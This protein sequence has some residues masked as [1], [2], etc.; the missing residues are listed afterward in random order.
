MNSGF[1]RDK[2]H[3]IYGYT[4]PIVRLSRRI[5]EIRHGHNL[6]PSAVIT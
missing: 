4:K 1:Q 3:P 5:L 2:G 6:V